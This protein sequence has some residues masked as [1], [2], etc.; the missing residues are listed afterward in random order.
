MI[1]RGNFVFSFFFLFLFRLHLCVKRLI[2]NTNISDCLACRIADT[3][4]KEAPSASPRCIGGASFRLYY[5]F[6][7]HAAPRKPRLCLLQVVNVDLFP[8]LWLLF[9]DCNVQRKYSVTLGRPTW[10]KPEIFF[11]WWKCLP[12]LKGHSIHLL[13]LAPA[14]VQL[15]S[16]VPV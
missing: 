4:I 10:P 1:Y 2:E 9:S 7:R 13:V 6:V 8:E 12:N 3:A 11:A 16:L 5:L 14:M 15:N